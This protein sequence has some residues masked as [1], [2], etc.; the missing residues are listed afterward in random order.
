MEQYY[1]REGR[2][3]ERYALIKARP[4]AGDLESGARLLENLRPRLIWPGAGR[5][6]AR[7]RPAS[8][9]NRHLGRSQACCRLTMLVPWVMENSATSGGGWHPSLSGRAAMR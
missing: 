9:M 8:A 5:V 6:Q 1:Q 7:T 4:V 3:W 2:D